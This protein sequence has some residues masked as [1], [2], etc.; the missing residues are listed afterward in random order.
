[1]SMDPYKGT[2]LATF[3]KDGQAVKDYDISL[4]DMEQVYVSPSPYCDAFEEAVDLR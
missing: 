1:M 2:V 3:G 4:R